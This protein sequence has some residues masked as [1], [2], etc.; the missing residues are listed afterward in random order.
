MSPHSS[1]TSDM[2]IFIAFSL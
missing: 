1:R 2:F